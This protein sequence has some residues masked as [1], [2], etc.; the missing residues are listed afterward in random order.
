MSG[1]GDIL[2]KAAGLGLAGAQGLGQV[3]QRG[4]GLAAPPAPGMFGAPAQGQDAGLSDYDFSQNPLGNLLMRAQNAIAGSQG[5]SSVSGQLRQQRTAG[6]DQR[7]KAFAQG[8]E[9]LQQ[10]DAIRDKASPADYERIDGL[11]KKRFA[12]VAGGKAGEAD[13]FYDTFMMGRAG[14][15]AGLLELAKNDPGAQQI[16]AAGGGMGELRKYFTSPEKL[17]EAIDLYDQKTLPEIRTRILE[18]KGSTDPSARERLDALLQPGGGL[19]LEGIQQAF[20]DL[21]SA[22]QWAAAHRHDSELTDLNL[23]ATPEILKRRE[24]GMNSDLRRK[25]ETEK[26]SQMQRNAIELAREKATL[27]PPPA[28]GRYQYGP[29]DG[30]YLAAVQDAILKGTPPPT[31][32]PTVT[33]YA[34]QQA[35]MR[36]Q[37]DKGQRATAERFAAPRGSL[38]TKLDETAQANNSLDSIGEDLPNWATG[39]FSNKAN[40]AA[41]WL[42]ADD[43]ARAAI[44]TRLGMFMDS[45]RLTTTGQAA[46]DKELANIEAKVPSPNDKPATAAA[47]LSEFQRYF[48][49]KLAQHLKSGKNSKYDVSRWEQQAAERGWNVMPESLADTTQGAA[50]QPPVPGAIQKLYKGKPI[51]VTSPDGGKTFNPVK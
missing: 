10:F 15:T 51:W 29:D 30:A 11:L 38:F 42:A 39:V 40:A 31:P 1:L 7:L 43:P 27:R 22:Q 2:Q 37:A 14:H 9:L 49:M 28:Q 6:N 45:Y 26:L 8:T 34:V 50:E 33:P 35:T 18:A 24:A 48:R 23:T 16:I 44:N 5:Q 4:L 3:A 41:W 46:G 13:E 19:T 12:E 20:P 36:L 21:L 25:E 47:K 32:G 17:K